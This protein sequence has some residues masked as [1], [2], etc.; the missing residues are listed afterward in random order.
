MERPTLGE[1]PL[2]HNGKLREQNHER[3]VRTACFTRAS[4]AVFGLGVAAVVGVVAAAA[5]AVV[6]P[7][8]DGCETLHS[9][10]GGARVD[11]VVGAAPLG[12]PS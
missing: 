11:N 6:Q 5:E 2:I 10:R 3:T 7:A 8:V 4:F 1:H 12:D 9:V